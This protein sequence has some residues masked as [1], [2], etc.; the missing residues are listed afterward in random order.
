LTRYS[1]DA[2]LLARAAAQC[3]RGDHALD[4]LC[5]KKPVR[6]NAPVA[7]YDVEGHAR[8]LKLL[9]ELPQPQPWKSGF[10]EQHGGHVLFRAGIG[11]DPGFSEDF[12]GPETTDY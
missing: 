1:H 5:G 8:A 12:T 4:L 10:L 11:V 6:P 2:P 7:P 9:A 3:G